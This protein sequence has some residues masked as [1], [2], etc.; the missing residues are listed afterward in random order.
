MFRRLAAAALSVAFLFAAAASAFAP[1][2]FALDCDAPNQH[3]YVQRHADEPG[4]AGTYMQRVSSQL[5]IR[6][7]EN[8]P[9]GGFNAILA[10]NIQGNT[11]S[12]YQI[13]Y[14]NDGNGLKFVYAYN[15]GG[16]AIVWPGGWVPTV[17]RT[18]KFTI[19]RGLFYGTQYGYNDVVFTIR[20]MSNGNETVVVKAQSS[21][22]TSGLEK[23]WWGGEHNRRAGEIGPDAGETPLILRYMAY[24][25]ESIPTTYR[26]GMSSGEVVN[27]TDSQYQIHGHI[28]DW[29]YGGDG[30]Q[31]ETH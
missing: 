10:A 2:T 9:C 29:V 5:T 20:D 26:S 21:W 6:S 31:L 28:T 12:I 3:V 11:S 24:E 1:A 4:I 14:W 7:L 23:A 25:T 16:A 30:L 17:G 19:A 22:D 18:Y 15:N 27:T 13:G 8:D